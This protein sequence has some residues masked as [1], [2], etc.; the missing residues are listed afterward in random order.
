[1]LSNQVAGVS[2]VSVSTEPFTHNGGIPLQARRQGVSLAPD[3]PLSASGLVTFQDDWPKQML[4]R[5]SLPQPTAEFGQGSD[6]PGQVL[7]EQ[8]P[9]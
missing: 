7:A 8:R 2:T 6:G 9:S 5:G 3:L 1:M 4:S